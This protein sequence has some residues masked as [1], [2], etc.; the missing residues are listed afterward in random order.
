MLVRFT[1]S[2]LYGAEAKARSCDMS[3]FAAIVCGEA[4]APVAKVRKSASPGSAPV[5]NCI[6][7]VYDGARRAA[8]S[9]VTWRLGCVTGATAWYQ[10][11]VRVSTGAGIRVAWT[12]C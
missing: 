9:A 2:M 8:T 5:A 11:G 4:P 7:H 6:C 1:V 3:R 12:A 10:L